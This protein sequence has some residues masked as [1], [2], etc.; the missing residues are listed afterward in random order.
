MNRIKLNGVDSNWFK[1]CSL[2]F[3][4]PVLMSL[5][6][7]NI[8]IS[9]LNWIEKTKIDLWLLLE[10]FPFTC[11]IITY[12][13]C[14]KFSGWYQE[15]C[16]FKDLQPTKNGKT[17]PLILTIKQFIGY[18]IFTTLSIISIYYIIQNR[19][20]IPASTMGTMKSITPEDH[21]ILKENFWDKNKRL[22][23]PMSPHLGI[24]KVILKWKSD[25][26]ALQ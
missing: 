1:L 16:C 14:T 25:N 22:T 11:Y 3:W 6:V 2:Y 15:I 9:S 20:V 26:G 17:I 4:T 8:I 24:Y 10:T 19:S 23:R 5:L 7:R 13:K 21:K 12:L 18:N